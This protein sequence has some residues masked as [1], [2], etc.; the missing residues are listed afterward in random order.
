MLQADESTLQQLRDAV[1]AA[2]ARADVRDAVEQVY[3]DL[4]DEVAR[5]RPVCAVSGR[6]CRF[7]EFG[8]RLFVT[9]AELATFLHGLGGRASVR[10]AGSQK[11]PKTGSDGASPSR[12]P[13]IETALSTWDGSGCP[14]Q[15]AKLCGVHALRP[16]GCRIFFCDATATQ[17]QNDAYETFHARLR[18]LHEELGLPYFYV[19]WRQALRAVLPGVGQGGT[20]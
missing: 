16:F 14:F 9:T 17:W 15:I 13:A 1:H 6:C 5:R 11:E 3:R 19:E 12:N 7:E 10:A 8:H 4:A 2:A 18:R 20:T